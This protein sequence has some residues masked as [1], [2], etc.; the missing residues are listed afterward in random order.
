MLNAKASKK[1][2][3]QIFK[4]RRSNSTTQ[5][6]PEFKCFRKLCCLSVI[7]AGQE[8]EIRIGFPVS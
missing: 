7:D 5:Q 2:R 1:S 4:K 6:F 8:I 3:W